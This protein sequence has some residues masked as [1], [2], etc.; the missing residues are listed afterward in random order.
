MELTKQVWEEI[1]D[2]I[3]QKRWLIKE[4]VFQKNGKQALATVVTF[5]SD[6]EVFD[7]ESF[8]IDPKAIPALSEKIANILPIKTVKEDSL[9]KAFEHN[10][11]YP[12]YKSKMRVYAKPKA[13]PLSDLIK[14]LATDSEFD[15]YFSIIK[16]LDPIH[17]SSI[18]EARNF[19]K[20]NEFKSSKFALTDSGRKFKGMIE[21]YGLTLAP[22]SDGKIEITS[23]DDVELDCNEYVTFDPMLLRTPVNE[24]SWLRATADEI[25]GLGTIGKPVKE[26][27][28]KHLTDRVFLGIKMIKVLGIMCYE[29]TMPFEIRDRNYEAFRSMD[30]YVGIMR[31]Y[32]ENRNFLGTQL[33]LINPKK[34]EEF[35]ALFYERKAAAGE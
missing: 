7:T 31:T 29:L 9:Q 26:Q 15:L 23:R 22:I 17:K 1:I 3:A 10:M 16:F 25:I 34:Y 5:D 19:T 2:F 20:K 4:I 30:V 32:D 18:V 13:Q 27:E 6:E 8:E 21:P 12:L 35:E 28:R 24:E 33:F 11:S 14:M